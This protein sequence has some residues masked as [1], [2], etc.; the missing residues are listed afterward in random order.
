MKLF[1]TILSFVLADIPKPTLVY[2]FTQ[3][4]DHFSAISGSFQQKVLVYDKYLNEDGVIF[5]Y[6]GNEG[7]IESFYYNTGL[8]FDQAEAFKA[9]IIFPEHRYYGV[10]WPFG[11]QSFTNENLKYLTVEQAIADFVLVIEDYKERNGIQDMPVIAFGGSYGGMLA[12]ATRIH[13]PTV[14][15]MALA[16]SAPIPQALNGNVPGTTFFETTTE[17]YRQ[18]NEQCPGKIQ[19]AFQMLQ[20]AADV[21]DYQKLSDLFLTCNP[22]K[23]DADANHLI[24]WARN[25]FVLL[26]MLDYPYP[27]DFLGPLPGWPVR[28][29]C[30]NM[31]KYDGLIGLREAVAPAY[32]ASGDKPCFDIYAE[33]IECADQTG[34][35]LGTDATAWDY[36]ACTDLTL[37]V[38][39][40]GKND[41]FLPRQWDHAN[42]TEYCLKTYN[43]QPRDK[44]M[45]LWWPL[46]N[47][48][49]SSS[50]II[51]SNGLL[52]PW[53]KGGYLQDLSS[54][55]LAVIVKDGAH[56][57]DLR[58]SNKDDPQSVITARQQEV[59][60]LQ[61]WLAQLR[62]E[63]ETERLQDDALS[64]PQT[65]RLSLF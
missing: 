60:I 56:H 64:R 22:I 23:N 15:D 48:A 2:N 61:G 25:A 36:Q 44:W 37:L 6:A 11:E 7:P 21:G 39:T 40:D 41:M 55:L 9:T 3:T 4:V 29:S 24:L 49:E 47:P 34:C 51:Y 18:I 59:R 45:R 8:M 32:N 20:Q 50:R 35:G 14:V 38:Y 65:G 13:Y 1:L 31:M 30:E 57:L 33:Y 58:E 17:D 53:H 10:S 54:D 46:D 16:A 28:V 62:Q 19:N 42:L 63:K 5:F 52:D 27:T 43:T 12:A 26:S